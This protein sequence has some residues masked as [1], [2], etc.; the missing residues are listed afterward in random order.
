MSNIIIQPDDD[1]DYDDIDDEDLFMEA[2]G[3]NNGTHALI[4][5]ETVETL[6]ET[7]MGMVAIL[8]ENEIEIDDDSIES[9]LTLILAIAQEAGL[10]KVSMEEDGR[11]LKIT[12]L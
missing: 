2:V 10:V 7:M 3:V 1:L 8:D 5:N 12:N 9:G 4:P 11:T 6:F